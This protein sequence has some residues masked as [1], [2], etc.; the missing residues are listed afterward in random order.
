MTSP[1]DHHT[2]TTDDLNATTELRPV[3]APRTTP[4]TPAPVSVIATVTPTADL[5]ATATD[6][7]AATAPVYEYRP[8]MAPMAFPT[9]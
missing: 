1:S 6:M 8:A 2:V 4:T 5:S 3:T 9:S 7:S